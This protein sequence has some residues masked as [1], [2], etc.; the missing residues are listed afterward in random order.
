MSGAELL[1]VLA[2]MRL[3]LAERTAERDEALALL[4]DARTRLGSLVAT[5]TAERD[6]LMVECAVLRGALEAAQR[7]LSTKASARALAAR[8]GEVA[9]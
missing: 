9:P 7:E 3:R 5:S 6:G 2:D 1:G 8:D 4:R